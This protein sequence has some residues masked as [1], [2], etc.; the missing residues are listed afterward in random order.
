MARITC[1]GT[2]RP[3]AKVHHTG[4]VSFPAVTGYLIG[5]IESEYYST[6]PLPDSVRIQK[7]QYITGENYISEYLDISDGSGDLLDQRHSVYN[8]IDIRDE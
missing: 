4:L 7:Y 6:G 1:T 2:L 3:A 8:R 5:E